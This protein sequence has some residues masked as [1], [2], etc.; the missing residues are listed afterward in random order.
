M[1][2]GMEYIAA[3]ASGVLFCIA[4]WLLFAQCSRFFPLMEMFSLRDF[5]VMYAR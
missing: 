5:E 3:F 2:E 1:E 4:V